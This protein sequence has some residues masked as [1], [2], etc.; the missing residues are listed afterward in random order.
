MAIVQETDHSVGQPKYGIVVR[1]NILYHVL[2]SQIA[3]N[4]DSEIPKFDLSSYITNYTGMST[5][6]RQTTESD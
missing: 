1:G 5:A 6:E 2:F 3:A 4:K